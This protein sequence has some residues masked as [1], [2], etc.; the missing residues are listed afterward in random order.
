VEGRAALSLHMLMSSVEQAEQLLG[1]SLQTLETLKPAAD[2][3]PHMR[4]I[5]N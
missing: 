3:P 4:L 1:C 2:S 5:H